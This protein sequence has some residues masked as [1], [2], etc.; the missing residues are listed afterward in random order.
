MTVEELGVTVQSCE[1][2]SKKYY[3]LLSVLISNT[4]YME[5]DE[6]IVSTYF[7]LLKLKN[8]NHLSVVKIVMLI[9]IKDK[10]EWSLS[11][12]FLF[13]EDTKLTEFY[14]HYAHDLEPLRSKEYPVD[15][16]DSVMVNAR[17]VSTYKNKV[18]DLNKI[19]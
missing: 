13:K 19:K 10:R 12:N 3:K 15:E 16:L 17:D 5:A 9:G 7:T 14:N 11:Q 2:I 4:D 1:F 18:I 8:F 6:I